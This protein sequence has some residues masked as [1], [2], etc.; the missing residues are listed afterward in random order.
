[1]RARSIALVAALAALG[2]GACAP[3]AAMGP[4]VPTQAAAGATSAARTVAGVVL[5]PAGKPFAGAHLLAIA[6]GQ[7]AEGV[8]DTAGRFSLGLAGSGPIAVTASAHDGQG[9][10]WRAHAADAAGELTLKLAAPGSVAGRVVVDGDAAGTEVHL[11]EAPSVA[12]RTDAAGRFVLADV[13]DGTWTLV[14]Q[15]P[16]YQRQRL[17]RVVVRDGREVRVLAPFHLQK[18]AG[19]GELRGVVRDGGGQPVPGAIA[20]AWSAT[21]TERYHAR[22]DATGAFVVPGLPAGT[23]HVQVARRFLTSPPRRDVAVP[24]A[25]AAEAGTFDL[26]GTLARGRVEGQVVDPAGRGVADAAVNLAHS[27]LPA[28]RTDAGG[29]YVFDGVPYGDYALHVA[30]ELYHDAGA[31]LHVGAAAVKV[32]DPI[33]A[34]P[35][36]HDPAAPAPTTLRAPE[37]SYHAGVMTWTPVRAPS[38]AKVVYDIEIEQA[39][40][41]FA[42]HATVEQVMADLPAAAAGDRQVRVRARLASASAGYGTAAAMDASGWRYNVLSLPSDPPGV[43]TMP[44]TL[45]DIRGLALSI[46]RVYALGGLNVPGAPNVT[47]GA[48]DVANYGETGAFTRWHTH[49]VD[50]SLLAWAGPR[51]DAYGT[52]V[53]RSVAK[54]T[55]YVDQTAITGN[56]VGAEWADA[57][58]GPYYPGVTIN[59]MPTSDT[60]VL[61]TGSGTRAVTLVAYP[62]SG[63]ASTRKIADT[64]PHPSSLALAG[65]SLFVM[66]EDGRYPS[67]KVLARFTK[68]GVRVWASGDPTV[69]RVLGEDPSQLHGDPA[70][71]RLYVLNRAGGRVPAGNIVVIDDQ[72]ARVSTIETPSGWQVAGMAVARGTTTQT[73]WVAYNQGGSMAHVRKYVNGAVAKTI[74][75]P[76]VTVRYDHSRD[77][78]RRLMAGTDGACWLTTTDKRIVRVQ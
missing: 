1:M 47:K 24:A 19:G 18:Q 30:G 53:K 3:P 62:P 26:A 40:G 16:G 32:A 7:I 68:A 9:R 33:V 70:G 28:V 49:D 15:R 44:V 14:A 12:A 37:A 43:A 25:G 42:R 41:Q 4:S 45:D 27:G 74:D 50:L 67:L 66:A 63:P 51:V 8:S 35:A 72:G 17:E 38:D 39:P 76:G 52:R 20:T 6:H 65:D 54:G 2:L 71:R 34:D 11:A 21:G 56:P 59:G 5:D 22:T 36:E 58:S 78:T 61:S 29:R 23:Y 60:Y 55:G 31:D 64:F 48:I 73:L 75:L 57:I 13:P 46:D 10:Q 69:D 77:T